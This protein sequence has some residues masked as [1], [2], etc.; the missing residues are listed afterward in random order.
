MP[1]SW[2]KSPVAMGSPIYSDASQTWGTQS[3]EVAVHIIVLLPL[4]RR[5]PSP[6]AA[7]EAGSPCLPME[8]GQ[9]FL[10]TLLFRCPLM[11]A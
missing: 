11:Q 6:V 9:N 10:S 4:F 5:C 2:L 7:G 8:P 3:G 1:A